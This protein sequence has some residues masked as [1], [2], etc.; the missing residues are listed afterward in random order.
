MTQPD[1]VAIKLLKRLSRLEDERGQWEY[2]WQELAEYILPRKADINVQ[3]TAGDKR[4]EVVFDSTAFH[5]ADMLAASIHGMLT[6]PYSPWFDLR[7]RDEALNQDDE[8]KEFL[9]E[10]TQALHRVFQR[11]NFA[12]AVH[13][14]YLDLVTFGTGVML[15]EDDE[16]DDIRFSSRHIK[17]CFLVENS[18]GRVDTVYRKFKMSIRSAA[19]QFG[20][21][22]LGD[23]LQ[24]KMESDPHEEHTFVH[25][26]MPRDDRDAERIDSKNMAF[27]SIYLEPEQKIVL[28]EGGYREFSYVCPRYLKSSFEKGYGRSPGMVALPDVKM[29]NRMSE[30]TIKAAQK[31]TDPP[32]MVP[33]DGFILPVRTRPGA[34]NFYRSGTRDRIEPLNIG[35][36]N[37]LGLSL[38]EQ[39]RAAIR[40]AFFVDQLILGE[41]PQMTATEV[42]QRTE[43]KMRLLGP[44]LGRLQAE[45]LQPMLARVYSLAKRRGLLPE[46]P[47]ALQ[48]A[49]SMDV[50]Y[51]SPLAK[52]QRTAD[53][54]AILRMFEILSPAASIDPG[55]FDHVDMDGMVRH[56][57]SVLAIPAKVTEGE[58]DVGLK[59]Q[60]R[61][62]QQQQAAEMQA[63]M[64]TA[65][66]MGK[67]AP[68]LEAITGALAAE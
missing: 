56:L 21:E 2:H 11:T 3:R 19:E 38:E 1:D 5:A 7:F 4:M 52:A 6:N 22:Q 53:V 27:A 40:S 63:G 61:A 28:S 45:L 37:P 10:T 57:F 62:D 26:V 65:E 35:A 13:E 17:E 33:D 16:E 42:V 23:K 58:I 51:V 47:E 66:A 55:V 31:Q 60:E 18:R 46:A 12:E 24:K 59:R 36:N 32:L 20:V 49:A 44:V 9:E 64:Q 43:E 25:V 14:L 48:Q 54:Q 8:S 67:A 30:V 41:G 34:L 29:L 15:I 68:G 50:E 39:R